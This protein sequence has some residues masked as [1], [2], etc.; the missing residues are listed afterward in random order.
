MN[1]KL[2]KALNWA[3][4]IAGIIGTLYFTSSKH[5]DLHET[6]LNG[7]EVTGIVIGR[8]SGRSTQP[9]TGSKSVR[10]I[11]NQDGNW[12]Q[13][14]FYG[15]EY[16]EKAIVGMKYKVKYRPD[17]TKNSSVNHSAVI[18][19]DEP[20]T[21]EYRNIIQTRE[22]LLNEYYSDR[23][24]LKGARDLTEINHMVPDSL[25]GIWRY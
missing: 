8:H 1:K 20:I 22:W 2:K 7:E 9:G 3:V 14:M 21:S 25:K 12:I 10:F 23:T 13:G 24:S 5:D 6:H 16:Y 15:E 19:V 18:Y 4:V 11:F 17:E